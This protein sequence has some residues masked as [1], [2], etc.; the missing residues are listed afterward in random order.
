M[1][2]VGDVLYL[3]GKQALHYLVTRKGVMAELPTMSF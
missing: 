1:P 3:P 2:I